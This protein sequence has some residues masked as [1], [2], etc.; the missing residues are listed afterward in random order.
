[1]P[2]LKAQILAVALL[3]IIKPYLIVILG[4]LVMMKA[5]VP[6]DEI[7]MKRATGYREIWGLF[8][9]CY[10]ESHMPTIGHCLTGV[11]I[12]HIVWSI[13]NQNNC[14]QWYCHPQN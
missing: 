1:M 10:G 8:G 2:I 11:H 14:R 4:I 7:M 13:Y 5:I 12:H 3:I 9:L 6:Y